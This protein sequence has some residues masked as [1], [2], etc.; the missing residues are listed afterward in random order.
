M[1]CRNNHLPLE[2]V[3]LVWIVALY[4]WLL[5]KGHYSCQLSLQ[6]TKLA[7]RHILQWWRLIVTPG[8][9]LWLH[10]RRI[11]N[12]VRI[13]LVHLLNT[14]FLFSSF[15]HLVMRYLWNNPPCLPDSARC[16]C[17]VNDQ[18][19]PTKWSCGFLPHCISN[20][21]IRQDLGR[22]DR[23]QIDKFSRSIPI[24]Y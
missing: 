13:F 6:S 23:I 19:L 18:M 5:Q 3:V 10:L 14:T 15:P 16:F 2:A 7:T 21:S 20:M 24:S 8:N 12:Q 22:E 9:R 11:S 17:Y 1:I 4:D